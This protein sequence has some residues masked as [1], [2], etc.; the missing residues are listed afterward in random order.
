MGAVAF[1]WGI[2]M[3]ADTWLSLHAKP[4]CLATFSSSLV[5]IVLPAVLHVRSDKLQ[6]A[7]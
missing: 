6:V 1:V 5:C 4:P 2:L 7:K 3:D